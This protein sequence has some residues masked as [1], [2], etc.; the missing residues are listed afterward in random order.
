MRTLR[1]RLVN[2]KGIWY[3]QRRKLFF[4][5]YTG[6]VNKQNKWVVNEFNTKKKAK[7]FIKTLYADE[8]IQY[9]TIKIL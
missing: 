1:I 3:L 4:W 7:Q 6:Y 2:Y 5:I 9:P 8:V